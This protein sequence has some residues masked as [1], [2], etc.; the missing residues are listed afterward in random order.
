MSSIPGGDGVT[1]GKKRGVKGESLDKK[2][3]LRDA[4]VSRWYLALRKSGKPLPQKG[5]T[6]PM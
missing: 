3:G 1:R 5:R 2:R 4:V 6:D